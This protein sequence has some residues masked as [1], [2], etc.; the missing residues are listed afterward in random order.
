MSIEVKGVLLK[1]AAV[2]ANGNTYSRQSLEKVADK[3]FP[4]VV[5]KLNPAFASFG[6]SGR[7]KVSERDEGT[8]EIVE[9]TLD[10]ISIIPKKK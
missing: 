9:F 1:A 2:S 8:K 6:L 7:G 5:E 4:V 10:S 3:S